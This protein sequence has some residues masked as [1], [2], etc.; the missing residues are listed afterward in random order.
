MMGSTRGG[1]AFR[2]VPTL[3]GMVH[4]QRVKV[5]VVGR[6]GRVKGGEIKTGGGLNRNVLTI[7]TLPVDNRSLEIIRYFVMS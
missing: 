5:A 3:V 1:V 2:P 6:V 4:T 7:A